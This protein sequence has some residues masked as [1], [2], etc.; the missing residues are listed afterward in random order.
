MEV[1]KSNSR[2]ESSSS[3]IWSNISVLFHKKN[4]DTHK[5]LD[6]VSGIARSGE[7]LAIMGASGVGKL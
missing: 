4:K 3:L 1:L 6:N 7:I 2:K 5:L